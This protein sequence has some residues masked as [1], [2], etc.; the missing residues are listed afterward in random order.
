[1]LAQRLIHPARLV[2]IL[3]GHARLTWASATRWRFIRP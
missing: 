3:A 2:D 1:V